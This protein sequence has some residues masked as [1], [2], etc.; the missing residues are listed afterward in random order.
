MGGGEGVTGFTRGYTIPPLPLPAGNHSKDTFLSEGWGGDEG[1]GG[2]ESVRYTGQTL[3][4]GTC[5]H[6]AVTAGKRSIFSFISEFYFLQSFI[7]T[8]ENKFEK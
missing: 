2:V 8:L 1:G 6:Y 7:R 4:A 3:P 5:L